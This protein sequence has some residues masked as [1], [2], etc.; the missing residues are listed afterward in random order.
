MDAAHA[1][2]PSHVSKR[3]STPAHELLPDIGLLLRKE[4]ERS[5]AEGNHSVDPP[6]ARKPKKGD[7]DP[8]QNLGDYVRYGTQQELIHYVSEMD[9][10]MKFQ[11]ENVATPM[12]SGVILKVIYLFLVPSHLF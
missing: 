4:D 11:R 10:Q 1:R 5:K 6:R 12:F 3:V 7:I 8:H 2:D 9:A